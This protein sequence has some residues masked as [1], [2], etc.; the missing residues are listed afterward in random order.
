MIL[1]HEKFRLQDESKENDFFIEVNWNPKDKKTNEC[2]ILKVV[3]PNGDE[4][5]IKRDHLLAFI[6]AIG[7]AEDQEKLIPQKLE[8]VHWK[9]T[10][11]GVRAKQDI[12]KGEM[13]NFPVELSVPCAALQQD[14]IGG[15]PRGAKV[16]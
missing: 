4:A 10:V 12:Q 13:I 11:L 9:R 7:K 14:V 1:D 16:I 15:V 3:F 8:P 6:F 5:F 2:K